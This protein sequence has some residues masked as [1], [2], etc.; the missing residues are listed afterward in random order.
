MGS[1]VFPNLCIGPC[2]CC[3]NPKAIIVSLKM[4]FSALVVS[5]VLILRSPSIIRLLRLVIFLFK[6]SVILLMKV[7]CCLVVTAGWRIIYSYNM[8]R[9]VSVDE[10]AEYVFH[11]HCC[12]LF[13]Q[14][15][16]IVL[17]TFA[18]QCN[19]SSLLWSLPVMHE[20]IMV[21]LLE[22]SLV[23]PWVISF[24]VF[25]PCLSYHCHINTAVLQLLKNNMIFVPD[26]SCIKCCY[27]HVSFCF[28]ILIVGHSDTH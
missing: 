12:V 11:C 14:F 18:Y 24:C 1:S 7:V 17:F 28:H 8:N 19:A 3:S 16:V 25:E 2:T 10:S 22:V 27:S 21:V 20:D 5:S 9:F 23:K 13:Q 26:Q 4:V 6:R 15:D